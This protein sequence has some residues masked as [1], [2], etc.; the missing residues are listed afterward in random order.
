MPGMVPW[1]G[2]VFHRRVIPRPSDQPS[3]YGKSTFSGCPQTTSL[4]GQTHNPVPKTQ[5]QSENANPTIYK[6]NQ[7]AT[8]PCPHVSVDMLEITLSTKELHQFT[9]MKVPEGSPASGTAGSGRPQ[10]VSLRLN[11]FLF[12]VLSSITLSSISGSTWL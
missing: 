2:R 1:A 9:R 7:N 4:S 11:F 5:V 12:W 8:L 6:G 3:E 10:I